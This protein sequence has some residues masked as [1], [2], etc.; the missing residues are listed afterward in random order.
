MVEN[1]L[2]LANGR[3]NPLN[4]LQRV[5]LTL[6]YYGSGSFQHTSGFMSGVKKSTANRSIAQVTKSLCRIAPN[7]IQMP[8]R[9][10]MQET[11]NIFYERLVI[12]IETNK[13]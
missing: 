6:C 13:F 4:P 7:I 8:K 10:K 9:S 5:C 11:A 1:D 12:F 2:K 3:G